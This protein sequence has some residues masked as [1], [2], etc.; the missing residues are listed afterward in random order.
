M[1]HDPRV[2]QTLARLGGVYRDPSRIDR[3]AS[4]LV[5]SS[6]GAYLRPIAAERVDDNGTVNREL[7]LQGTI[8]LQFRGNTYQ[9][10]VDIYLPAGYP[11]HPPICFVR[12]A[13]NMYLKENHRHVGMD[14]RVYLPYLHE[15]R[16]VSHNL[17]ELV[18]AMSSVFSA[19]PPVFSRPAGATTTSAAAVVGSSSTS[20]SSS[21]VLLQQQQQQSEQQLLRQAAEESRRTAEL[22]EAQAA[23]EAIRQVELAEA[24]E[25][26]QL[27]AQKAW[28]EQRT[29]QVRTNVSQKITKHLQKL[30]GQ[31]QL[32]IQTDFKDTQRLA[33]AREE[34]ID[35]QLQLFRAKVAELEKQCTVAEVAKTDIQLW[36]EEAAAVQ[37]EQRQKDGDP[38]ASQMISIDEIVRPP[39]ALQEQM[40][41]LSAENAAIADALYFLDKA[42]DKGLLNLDEHLKQVRNL[43]KRQFLV[44]AHLIKINQTLIRHE[45]T[46]G[47]RTFTL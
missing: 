25:R 39:N 13:E 4:A 23:A 24:R 47:R 40:L 33:V 44:R 45:R 2:S 38:S 29:N 21:W 18:V 28:E 31:V 15:W 32:A 22:A 26:E 41:D 43:A 42:L 34:K 36:L 30:S 37:E 17:I 6:A 27:L 3:D 10:L 20:S 1:A 5:R 9:Q 46:E 8:P 11:H 14:G 35:K 7:V 12:L 16:A 19:D